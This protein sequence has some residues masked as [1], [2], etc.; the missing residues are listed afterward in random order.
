MIDGLTPRQQREREFY[1]T[2]AVTQGAAESVD[3]EPILDGPDRPWNSYWRHF[4]LVKQLYS[5]GARLLDFGCGWGTITVMFAS[6]GYEVHGFDI[7]ENNI[8]TTMQR[9][10]QHAVADRVHARV[11]AAEQLEYPDAYFDVI[12]GVDILHH[13]DIERSMAECHR[14]LR[15]GGYALF[16]EPIHSPAFDLLRSSALVRRFFPASPSLDRHVTSDERKITRQEIDIITG[17][18]PDATLEYSRV[19]SRL[20]VFAPRRSLQLEQL[21]HKLRGL[22]GMRHLSGYC[23]FILR[24]E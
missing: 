4:R 13:V 20:A 17:V 14:V 7:S 18:F 21:D 19:F 12:S 5:P 15:S 3:L 6:L 24:K 22:P 23:N 1:D 10:E 2:Y 16:R 11:G 9:A 8:A